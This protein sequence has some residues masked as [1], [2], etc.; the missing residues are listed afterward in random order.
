[1]AKLFESIKLRG[2]EIKNRIV[3]PPMCMYSADNDGKPNDWHFTH[4]MTRA[5]GGAGLI[6]VEATGVE[7]CGRIT[8]RDLGIWKDEHIEGL[9]KIARLCKESGAAAGIQLGHAGRKSE[10]TSEHNIAP[11]AIAFSS[12]YRVPVEM[13]KEDIERVISA[14]KSG[15]ERALKAGF[16]IIEIHAAHG[17]LI[18]EFLSPLTNKRTDEY[19][20]S[21]ENRARFLVE[22]ISAVREVWPEDKPLIVR[23]SAAE[24]DEEGN[25]LEDI[26][27]LVEMAIPS[28]VDIIDVSTG[29]VVANLVRSYPGYQIKHA[30]IIKLQTD[31]PVIAGGI[32]SS[33]YMAEEI[34]Q[35]NR[36]DMIFLG[37]ELL[38]NPYWPLQAAEM[39]GEEVE[40]PNQ[41]LRSKVRR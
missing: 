8:N 26:S 40:W 37:R 35:N 4:Y 24:Y 36:A 3:M 16:D 41:Y 34:L 18:N 21:L 22:V 28:G 10:V 32:V 33:P 27:R 6:I 14:F 9:E 13:T 19:G 5:V 39:L 15:A 25:D 11:S 17:Y 38:R 20:D 1:M 23:V 30:E 31:L 12:E 7:S 29:G 2:L